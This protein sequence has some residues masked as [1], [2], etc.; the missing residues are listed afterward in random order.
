MENKVPNS[1]RYAEI[2]TYID[3]SIAVD[4][5]N[6][7]K[8]EDEERKVFYLLK[9]QFEK[10]SWSHVM[11]LINEL[12]N[13]PEANVNLNKAFAATKS[14][15]SNLKSAIGSTWTDEAIT[16]IFFIYKTINTFI[17][18]QRLWIPSCH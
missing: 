7:I 16:A 18:S 1:K 17:K 2:R 4:L 13:S 8:E 3:K 11:N 12:I 10:P 5:S 15:F 6:S 14:N 9:N